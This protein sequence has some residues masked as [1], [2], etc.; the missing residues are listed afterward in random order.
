MYREKIFIART[1]RTLYVVDDIDC[2]PPDIIAGS[3][4]EYSYHTIQVA[5]GKYM[6]DKR[7][8]IDF[9]L[10]INIDDF[11]MEGRIYHAYS[12]LALNRN[13]D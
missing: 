1:K 9:C 13:S 12:L 3:L 2:L 6:K 5:L 10:T 4:K 11:L 8:P 7:P